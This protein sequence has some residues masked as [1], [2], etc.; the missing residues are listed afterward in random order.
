MQIRALKFRAV[1]P[2]IVTCIKSPSRNW[3]IRAGGVVCVCALAACGFHPRGAESELQP[4]ARVHITG[5]DRELTARLTQYLTARGAAVTAAARA[6]AVIHI[7]VHEFH[8]ELLTTDAKGRATAYT[9]RYR[10]AYEV[11]GVA[12]SQSVTIERALP[13][14]AA[15]QLQFEHEKR[16]LQA[17]MRAEAARRIAQRLLRPQAAP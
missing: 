13:Y 5:A 11:A 9:L 10:V 1:C 15:L 8:Q 2:P 16:F 17:D 6:T 14:D 12:A 3:F 4:P 7:A